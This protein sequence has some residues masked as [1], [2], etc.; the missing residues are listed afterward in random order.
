MANEQITTEQ[1][2]KQA[3]GPVRK[4]YVKPMIVHELLL[5][6]QALGSI[7]DPSDPELI[8]PPLPS[9]PGG[10]TQDGGADINPPL[11][12][13]PSGGSTQGGDTNPPLPPKPPA[14]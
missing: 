13:K 12:P 5:T 10:S 4:P 6:T 8:N 2:D 11:P 1:S 14:P 9:K 3:C 7:V